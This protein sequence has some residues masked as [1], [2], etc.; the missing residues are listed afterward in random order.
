MKKQV[1][2][3]LALIAILLLATGSAAARATREPFTGQF[4]GCAL[5][6]PQPPDREWYSGGPD[7]ARFWHVRGMPMGGRAMSSHPWYN[8]DTRSRGNWDIELATLSGTGNAKFVKIVDGENRGWEGQI[9]AKI[10]NGLWTL[11]IVGHGTGELAGNKYFA[12]F[13]PIPPPFDVP[14]D[15]VIPD[16]CGDV[17]DAYDVDGEFLIL[18]SK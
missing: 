11:K 6:D 5:V 17:T 7:G 14:D 16:Y 13:T 2:L 18:P 4:F 9:T 12:T 10:S 15:L 8:A 3:A 1:F